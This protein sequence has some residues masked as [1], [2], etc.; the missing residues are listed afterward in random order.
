L[1]KRRS[2]LY[3]YSKTMKSIHEFIDLIIYID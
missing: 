3:N 1:V 2:I